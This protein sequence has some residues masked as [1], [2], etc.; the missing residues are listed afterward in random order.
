MNG[1]VAGNIRAQQAQLVVQAFIAAVDMAGFVQQ[2]GF[3]LGDQARQHQ[4]RACAQIG[5]FHRAAV[6]RQPAPLQWQ[7]KLA[8]QEVQKEATGA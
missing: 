4:R 7:N 6:Q 5:G 2:R 3:S 8:A 1:A